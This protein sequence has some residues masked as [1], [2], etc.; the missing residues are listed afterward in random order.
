M[1]ALD[2]QTL[3]SVRVSLDEVLAGTPG[4]LSSELAELGWADVVEADRETAAVLLFGAQGRALASTR[5]LDDVVTHALGSPEGT[6]VAYAGIL[7]GRPEEG[8][9]QV[10]AFD[11]N[12]AAVLPITE[13]SGRLRP[14]R[15]FDRVTTWHRLD[16]TASGEPLDVSAKTLALAVAAAR[17]ALTAE[18][19]GVC[20][21]ALAMAVSHTTV[22]HQYGRPLASFQ[23]VRHALAEA[24][25]AIENTR[26]TLE[27]AGVA[28]APV[29]TVA[30]AARVAKHRAGT[31]QALVMRHVVQVHGAM[32]LT[33]E[34]DVH[35]A[36]TRAAAL[37]VLLGSSREL[38]T[39]LGLDLLS[40]APA[41]P[42]AAI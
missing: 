3:A 17:R 25:A 21:T 36:V 30:R 23:A 7:L 29:A 33:L 32:G 20:E 24:H 1:T 13:V 6:V 40:G 34:S 18:I 15:G 37:D 12:A 26:A 2:A 19:V 39:R 38:S 28:D 16:T 35:R 8:T 42:I 5:L 27:A 11:E 31:T 10:V 4:D 9:E 41:E 14:V 22:R